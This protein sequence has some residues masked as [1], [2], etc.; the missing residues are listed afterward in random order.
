MF[1]HTFNV[2]LY[3]LISSTGVSFY[4]PEKREG[5]LTNC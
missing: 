5:Y 3:A 2:L 4:T 1:F